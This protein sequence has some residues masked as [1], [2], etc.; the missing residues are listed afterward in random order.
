[1]YCMEEQTIRVNKY[2][3]NLG[4]C[5]RRDV[6]QLLKHQNLQVNGK[7][8]KEPGERIDPYKD[9]IIL[10][11]KKIKP[12]KLVYYLL[13]KPKGI[14]STTSDEFGRDNVTK[15]ISTSER[16][17]PVGRL[18][19]DTTGLLILTN[20][21]TLTNQ[22][23]HPK[24]HVDK[25]YALTIHGIITREQLRALRNGVLLDDGITAP[26]EVKIIQG[27]N[28]KSLVHMTI[29]EGRNRQIR[30]MCGTVGVNLI[31]LKRISFGPIKLTNLKEGKSRELSAK[32]IVM[33][34]KAAHKQIT[35]DEV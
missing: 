19:K 26:A 25:T 27:N 11:G 28:I 33:L 13:N 1:M 6:K 29:H 5:S 22:L 15:F 21:G 9:T 17:Y 30:R 16:I 4:I 24:Y 20:D 7:Q 31:G 2:L 8:I 34:Q 35:N 32:E 3:A 12:P 14:I 10:N 18:D 23:T